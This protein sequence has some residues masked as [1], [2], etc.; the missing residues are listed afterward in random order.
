MLLV[1]EDHLE[2]QGARAL[3]PEDGC[4][5]L[6]PG[7]KREQRLCLFLL[8]TRVFKEASVLWMLTHPSLK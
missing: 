6:M 3:K 7:P 8:Q 5:E 4:Q 2:N 1:G